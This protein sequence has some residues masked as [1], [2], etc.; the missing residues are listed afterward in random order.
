MA[1]ETAEP[2]G[3]LPLLGCVERPQALLQLG[4][5]EV[6]PSCR[7]GLI[8]L[9]CIVIAVVGLVPHVVGQA[10]TA[11]HHGVALSRVILA[12]VLSNH[13]FSSLTL[14]VFSTSSLPAAGLYSAFFS[15][16]DS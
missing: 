12:M 8:E 9:D 7:S 4:P 14:L 3:E 15:D 6:L 2:L 5:L 1:D 11:H 13:A 16:S 10:L